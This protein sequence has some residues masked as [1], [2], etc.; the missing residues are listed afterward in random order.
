[1]FRILLALGLICGL[2]RFALA[3]PPITAIAFSPLGDRVVAISQRGVDI[4][5]YPQLERI[6]T[7]PLPSHS[8]HDLAF[9]P[10]G[11]QVAVA[12][13]A[14]SEIGELALLSWPAGMLLQQHDLHDDVIYRIAFSADGEWIANAAADRLVTAMHITDGTTIQLT[15]H[16]QPVT[17]VAFAPPEHLVTAGVDQSL[18]VWQLPEGRL[19]RTFENHTAAITDLVLRPPRAGEPTVMASAAEDRTV[20][21][22]Q[23]VV[24]RLL[25]FA[26]LPSVPQCLAWTH[27]GS[28]LV[29]GCRDG[30]VRVIDQN[31]VEVVADHHSIDG[32]VY[33]VAIHANDKVAVLGGESGEISRIELGEH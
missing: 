10:D 28:R 25:R 24:G 13:G 3:D 20:R 17:G 5:G 7:W 18:R 9:S 16:S 12:G 30:H 31:T 32:W 27:D 11:Q 33:A 8:V 1:M 14:A 4:Y 15:G 26:R 23:P 19:V 22:W 2:A 6:D 21:I 29:A